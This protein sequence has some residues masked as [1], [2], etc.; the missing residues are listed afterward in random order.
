MSLH[1]YFAALAVLS[2]LACSPA[3]NR[4]ANVPE[5]ARWVGTLK[6]GCFLKIGNREFS[7]W[8]MEGWD[9]DGNLVVEGIWELDGIA[10]ARIQPEEITKFDGSVFHL[11]DGARITRQ[12]LP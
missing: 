12:D 6:E 9:K 8:Q 1:K 2:A 4:P 11:D 5:D 10:R 7:G 3:P